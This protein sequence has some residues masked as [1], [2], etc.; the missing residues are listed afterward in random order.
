MLKIDA[1][2]VVGLELVRY[3]AVADPR[4]HC[5]E[6]FILFDEILGAD[7]IV[8]TLSDGDIAEQDTAAGGGLGH[9]DSNGE[10]GGGF[11]G[12]AEF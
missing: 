5:G 12:D 6:N 2:H 11:Q 8:K 9:G 4:H 1:H 10:V 7:G 3:R